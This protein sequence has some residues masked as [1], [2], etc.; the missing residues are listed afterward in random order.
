MKYV[1]RALINGEGERDSVQELAISIADDA[2][3]G[4]HVAELLAV[5]PSVGVTAYQTAEDYDLG[6]D[7][8]WRAFMVALR[9]Q[10]E[11]RHALRTM[12]RQSPMH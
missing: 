6:D 9:R 4:A 12:P 3:V 1:I 8:D 2:T 10:V 7:D 5:S 11:L